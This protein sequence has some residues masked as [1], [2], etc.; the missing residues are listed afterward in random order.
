VK[1]EIIIKH[2]AHKR[3][4]KDGENYHRLQTMNLEN[5]GS[6]FKDAQAMT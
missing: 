2:K 1:R 4:V 5:L 3:M 6:M